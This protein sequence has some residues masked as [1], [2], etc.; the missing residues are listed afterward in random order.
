MS[1]GV[2]CGNWSWESIFLLTKIYGG[3]GKIKKAVPSWKQAKSVAIKQIK[4]LREEKNMSKNF[5]RLIGVLMV[6]A[7]IS[8][9]AVAC[10]GKDEIAEADD[11]KT[12]TTVAEENEKDD[13]Q[14]DANRPPDEEEEVAEAVEPERETLTEEDVEALKASIKNAVIEEY[15]KPNGVDPVSFSWPVDSFEAWLYF[16]NL[17]FL[18]EGEKF[19][20]G[21]ADVEISEPNEPE[22]SI[23]DAIYNGFV[24][25]YE[26]VGVS[27][28][29]YFDNALSLMTIEWIGSIDVTTE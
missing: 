19:L 22:K 10:S 4:S 25:W 12:E 13:E 20:G 3:G 21:A 17:K 24:K 27:N 29:N 2:G 18:Y 26:S 23:M 5:K 9:M 14:E 28:H 6:A 7:M 11:S 1:A 16:D 8:A 15:I